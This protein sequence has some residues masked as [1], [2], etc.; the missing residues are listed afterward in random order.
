MVKTNIYSIFVL[1][2]LTYIIQE[3][4][5]F[6]PLTMNFS[7]IIHEN[8]EL[9]KVVLNADGSNTILSKEYNKKGST[10]ISKIDNRGNFVY[11]NSKF[12]SGYSKEAQIME[13][14]TNTG[15][16]TY[17]FYYKTKEKEF[18][19]EFKDKGVDQ[20]KKEKALDS[21]HV[22]ISTFILKNGYI[23]FAGIESTSNFNQT[24]INI[25]VYDPLTKEPLNTGL[26]INADTYL[27]SCVEV[28]DNEVYCTYI[29][30]EV[31]SPILKIHYFKIKEDGALITGKNQTFLIE[32]F[33]TK[34]N[35]LKAIKM[36]Q[37][38]I[39]IIFKIV[40]WKNFPFDIRVGKSLY[41]Y[42]LE[43]TP[44]K[45]DIIRYNYI[46][47]DCRLR[48]DSEDYTIDMISLVNNEIYIICEVDYGNGPDKFQLIK[49]YGTYKKFI[50]TTLTDLGIVVKNPQFIKIGD[51]IAILYTR[52]DINNK[53]DVMLLKMNYP[54]CNDTQNNFVLYEE[55]PYGKQTL[56]SSIG[57][58]FN[59]SLKNPYPLSMSSSPLY[60]KIIAS[61]RI[62]IINGNKEL[63]LNKDYN[64]SILSS[65]NLKAFPSKYNSYIEYIVSRKENN[66]QIYGKTCRINLEFPICLDQCKGCDKSG[67]K[68][69]H[70]CFECKY[71]NYYKE[72][73]GT[74]NTGCGKDHKLYNCYKC[75]IACEE[76]DGPFNNDNP[77]TNCKEDKCNIT[78]GYYPYEGNHKICFKESEKEYWKQK[79]HLECALF[80]DNTSKVEKEWVW[81]CC[82]PHC[83]SCHLKNTTNNHNCDT[84]NIEKNFF[85][86]CDQ[87]KGHGIPGKCHESC[88]GEGCYM[89]NPE[90][91]EGMKKMCPCFGH[92]KVCENYKT[93]EECYPT[94]FLHH[95]KTS[96]D[97]ECDYCYTPYFEDEPKKSKGKCIN[98]KTYF[99]P[100]EQYTFDN[101]CYTKNNMPSFNY[102]R[103]MSSL[104]YS[105]VKKY[106]HVI[107]K[108]CNLLT[109]CKNVKKGIIW[110]IH[111]I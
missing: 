26:T 97:K 34:I 96:C 47:N 83:G 74:D 66:N 31:E 49:I 105:V 85:F 23:F 98:C 93:C 9:G 69:D 39:G 38:E 90:E 107:D 37:N 57:S 54:Y 73:K 58:Y 87:T 21:Y 108:F 45:I 109:G 102:L 18:F 86:F 19:T 61:N 13:A 110:K 8:A 99:A 100:E 50:Q 42:H 91:T 81:R 62:K 76:C 20:M 64:I 56:L 51:I 17:I 67:T 72:I 12:K 4:Y 53:S 28:M 35:M 88:I 32:P 92:C 33:Y 65:L 101:K 5:T 10:F 75:N 89:S 7:E 106:Y 78:A 3:I 16:N 25:K 14:K 79:L 111:I 77:T 104:N 94:W 59:I 1:P 6:T 36:S 27:V 63:E 55:C 30:N 80:L 95:E 24:K 70:H 60:F 103:Y 68:E 15:N 40:N 71:N 84:C 46:Y 22:Q 43:V 29:Q 44:S 41:F 2:I 82:D 48:K 52:I 11:H